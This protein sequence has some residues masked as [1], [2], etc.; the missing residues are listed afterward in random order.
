MVLS[1]MYA[2]F[3]G[4]KVVNYRGFEKKVPKVR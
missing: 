1:E 2:V 3:D 4:V